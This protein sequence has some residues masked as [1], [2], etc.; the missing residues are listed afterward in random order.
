MVFR[1]FS[2]A[3]VTGVKGRTSMYKKP[4]KTLEKYEFIYSE[5]FDINEP[6]C[7]S[8]FLWM[9]DLFLTSWTLG[10][11]EVMKFLGLIKYYMEKYPY[12]LSIIHYN[13]P[14]HALI[15]LSRMSF[16]KNIFM[17]KAEDVFM[18]K[19]FEN[20]TKIFKWGISL[21]LDTTIIDLIFF[22]MYEGGTPTIVQ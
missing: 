19:W 18:L 1:M 5:N 3:D 17:Q 16:M 21:M 4:M 12:R 22:P 2:E 6:W 10:S 8:D 15:L 7:W 11:A 20:P 13:W 14:Y 9:E